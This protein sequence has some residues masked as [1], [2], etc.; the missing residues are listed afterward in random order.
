M[1]SPSAHT[2]AFSN[3]P[4]PSSSSS[5]LIRHFR[6]SAEI[7]AY[8]SSPDD[9]VMNNRPSSSKHANIGNRTT[10]SATTRSIVYPS[11][12]FGGT[13][14]PAH[15]PTQSTTTPTAHQTGSRSRELVRMSDN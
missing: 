8:R 4:F 11:A 3:V 2:L 12:A 7:S 13:A 1:T 14:A 15:V 10:P 9:S 6:V 5:T